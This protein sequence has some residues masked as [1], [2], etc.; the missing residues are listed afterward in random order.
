MRKGVIATVTGVVAVLLITVVVSAMVVMGYLDVSPYTD[1]V[2]CTIVGEANQA[3]IGEV[4]TLT[5]GKR[6]SVKVQ[7]KQCFNFDSKSVD[8]TF[9][10]VA[11]YDEHD[12]LQ[13][14]T[15]VED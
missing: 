12:V 11:V 1:V 9:K 6:T 10:V 7:K 14:I 13:S 5:L 8:D 15:C 3:A 2:E 4:Y